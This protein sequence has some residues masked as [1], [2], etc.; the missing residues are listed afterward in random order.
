VTNRRG[1]RCHVGTILVVGG[2][3]M[4]GADLLRAIADRGHHVR[5]VTRHPKKAKA[6]DGVDVVHGDLATGDGVDLAMKGVDAV[7][8]AATAPTN[9]MRID[10]E[11]TRRLVTAAANE[12]VAHLLYVSNV[13]IDVIPYSYYRG[14]F[15]AEQ[16]VEIGRV[17]WTI[18]RLT[19][20]HPFIGLLLGKLSAGPL[21]VAPMSVPLQPIGTVDAADCLATA[22]DAGPSGHLPDRGGP[23]VE[24]FVE[25]AAQWRKANRNGGGVLP[26]PVPGGLAR[27]LRDG[28]ATC[29]DGAVEGQT[30]GDWLA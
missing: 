9:S 30:F 7:V 24:S 23:R 5:A 3:G 8:H 29:P 6:P 28:G 18:Q 21:T 17:P 13:G 25:L 12:G 14:K 15:A 11:G 19:Q 22:L 2:T 1:K 20:F 27:A 16:I 10:I 26:V 4:L